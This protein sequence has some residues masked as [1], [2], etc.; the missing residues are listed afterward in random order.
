[1][2]YSLFLFWMAKL[3]TET[4]FM[5]ANGVNPHH[6][7]PNGSRPSRAGTELRYKA[8]SPHRACR[9]LKK[10]QH[11]ENPKP[12]PCCGQ[13]ITSNLLNYRGHS[14]DLISLEEAKGTHPHTNVNL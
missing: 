2:Q 13:H 5:F 14:Y 1:M 8:H 11:R 6:C 3:N 4:L 12:T 7:F 9:R 10:E